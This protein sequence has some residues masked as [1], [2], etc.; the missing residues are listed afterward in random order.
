[1]SRILCTVSTFALCAAPLA[2]Q[3]AMDLEMITV[4]ANQT[5]FTLAR[6][7]TSVEV[8]TGEQIEQSPATTLAD[9]LDDLPGVSAVGNGGPGQT[10]ALSIR[11]LPNR[12]APVYVQGIE[13]TD[14]SAPQAIFNFANVLPGG[15]TRAEVVKGSQSALY[16]SEAIAG[17]V[18]LDLARAPQE[19]GREGTAT[20]EAG[21]YGTRSATLTYGI[22]QDGWGLALSAS[23]FVT[24]GF[25]AVEAP[26]YDE[27]DGFAAT[28]FGLD[29][30]VD[31]TPDL[32]LGLSGFT[33]NS[34]GDYDAN[35]FGNPEEGTF[36]TDSYGLRAYAQLQTGAVAHELSFSRYDIDRTVSSGGFDDGFTSVRD[37]AAYSG[38]WQIDPDRSLTFGLDHSREEASFSAAT[39]DAFWTRNGTARNSEEVDNTGVFAEYAMAWTPQLDMVLS[40]RH[41]EHSE[42]GGEWSGRTALSYRATEAL[43]LRATLAKGYRAPS[44]YELFDPTYGNTNLDPETSRS[45]E[46]G[47]DYAFAGGARVGATIFHTEIED[48]I[49]YDFAV[50]GYAQ[51]PGTSVSRGVELTGAVPLG[52]RVDLTGSFTYTDARDANDDPLQRVPRYDLALGLDARITDALRAGVTLTHKADFPDTYGIGF[53]PE[54]VDDFTTVNASVSYEF[55]NGLQAYLRVE[56]LFDEQY[57]VVPDYQTSDRAAYFGIRASF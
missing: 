30:Y 51:V 13:T 2:A 22:A 32:R 48:L 20:L 39:Y 17:I 26:G 54:S 49:N 27:D 34:D 25:S 21:S 15:V 18:A 40:L 16:G 29:G 19:P 23:R 6:T 47:A 31:V 11:G 46:L 5:D 12:Y 33:F 36:S 57:N 37:V 45:Y 35:T 3:E 24:D 55:R 41:D 9:T 28:Q 44:L 14:T 1:M 52:A 42:F 53:A 7:G 43:T 56:N 10:T 50:G 4:Y 38:T 8:L